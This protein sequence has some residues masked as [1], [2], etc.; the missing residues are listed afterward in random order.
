[1][2]VMERDD[3]LWLM[4]AVTVPLRGEVAY[5]HQISAVPCCPL[6]MTALVQVSAPPVL[7][8]PVTVVF[9]P[10]PGELPE[11]NATSSSLAKF[12]VRVGVVMVVPV[13]EESLDTVAS[14]AS[15]CG[16]VMMLILRFVVAV[17]RLTSLTWTVKV[18]VP[19]AVGVPEIVPVAGLRVRPAGRLPEVMDQ[20]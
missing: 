17:A 9:A 19:V 11:I 8:T 10:V 6:V 16:V 18:L 13:A 14:M 20:V 4:V 3:T 2:T 7:V 12:V 1:M 5:A 15:A